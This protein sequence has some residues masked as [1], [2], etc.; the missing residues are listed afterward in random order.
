M[1]ARL[2]VGVRCSLFLP[3][4]VAMPRMGFVSRFNRGKISFRAV[5]PRR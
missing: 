3:I 2:R 1:G 5:L 4:T